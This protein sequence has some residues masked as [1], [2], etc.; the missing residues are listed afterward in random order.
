MDITKKVITIVALQ[1]GMP[2]DQITADTKLEGDHGLD[3]LDKV[4]IVMEVEDEFGLAI[5]DD[6]VDKLTTVQQLV[7]H[8]RLGI[9]Q[10][11]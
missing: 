2:V 6:A 1:A 4:E 3:S 11:A 8:V 9:Q 7:D 10:H 5:L